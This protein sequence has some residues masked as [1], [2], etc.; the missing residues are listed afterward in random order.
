MVFLKQFKSTSI[1]QKNPP[2]P[3][4]R[5]EMDKLVPSLSKAGNK[6]TKKDTPLANRDPLVDTTQIKERMQEDI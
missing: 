4:S 1:T 6:A 5:E 3:N 2:I